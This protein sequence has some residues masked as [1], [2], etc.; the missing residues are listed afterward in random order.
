MAP[1]PFVQLFRLLLL[2]AWAGYAVALAAGYRLT[3]SGVSRRLVIALGIVL[4]LL[5]LPVSVVWGSCYLAFGSPV[6][7][8]PFI[9]FA[10]SVAS[11]AR[12][13]VP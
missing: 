3:S 6:G 10:V 12:V 7:V 1:Q 11:L 13:A 9:Y 8:I 5:I 4:A 2:G